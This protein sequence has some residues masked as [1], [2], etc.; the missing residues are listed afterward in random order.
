MNSPTGHSRV[1]CWLTLLIS[2]VICTC[3]VKRPEPVIVPQATP[4]RLAIYLALTDKYTSPA[5][6]LRTYEAPADEISRM[7]RDLQAI[8]P[9]P[10]LETLH[11]QAVAAYESVRQGRLMLPGADSLLRAEAYFA[12]EWGVGRLLDY[13][14]RLGELGALRAGA[15]R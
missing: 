15:S 9:P 2:L 13:R 12:I 4:D 6:I 14:Q 5:V 10:G 3:C 11:S 8:T 1:C 7:Q